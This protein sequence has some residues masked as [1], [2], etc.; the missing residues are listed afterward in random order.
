MQHDASPHALARAEQREV[1][2]QDL[3]S[4]RDQ[5]AGEPAEQEPATHETQTNGLHVERE[6]H[7][8]RLASILTDKDGGTL[9]EILRALA[10]DLPQAAFRTVYEKVRDSAP[11]SP[12]AYAVA[13]LNRMKKEGQYA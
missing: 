12:S 7:A 9:L 8:F 10:R 5:T 3:V 1:Q 2:D 6:L 13:E 4:V 11:K